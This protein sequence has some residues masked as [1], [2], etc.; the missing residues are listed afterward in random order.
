VF[1]DDLPD[2]SMV[3]TMSAYRAAQTA[4]EP[5]TRQRAFAPTSAEWQDGT[6]AHGPLWFEDPFVM[7]GSDDQM[8]AVT[9]ED[10]LYFPYGVCRFIANVALL[11]LSMWIERPGT[12][13]CSDGVE[14]RTRDTGARLP[15]DGEPCSGTTTPPDVHEVWTF[16]E[17][18]SEDTV[19]SAEEPEARASNDSVQAPG[20]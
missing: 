18:S 15:Y 12:V 6:V 1:V 3:T 8:F 10:L 4:A 9:Q 11:P 14:G 7:G 13:M 5:T 2:S 16:D 17:Q 20:S 19:P